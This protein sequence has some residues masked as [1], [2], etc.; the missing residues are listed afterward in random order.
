MALN[1]SKN[2]NIMASFLNKKT[3]EGSGAAPKEFPIKMID[4]H[5]IMPNENNFYVITNPEGL[6]FEIQ[7]EPHNTLGILG[8]IDVIFPSITQL[9]VVY[10]KGTK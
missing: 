3:I 2:Q 5:D 1:S 8:C 10:L 6:A 9:Y 7:I 4:I